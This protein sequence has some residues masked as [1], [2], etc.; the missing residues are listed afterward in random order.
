MRISSG[1]GKHVFA[2]GIYL[3][4]LV[5]VPWLHIN[6]VIALSATLGSLYFSE[7]MKFP[8]C[9]LCWYQR[10][11]IYPLVGIFCAALLTEDRHHLKYSVPLLVL[12]LTLAIYHNLLY[13]G[14]IA[15]ELVPCT[16][17]VSCSSRQLEL[18]GF[19]TIPL[20]AL[21]SF[22]TMLFVV[23]FEY[24]SYDQL[25]S[26]TFAEQKGQPSCFVVDILAKS[27]SS[28]NRCPAVMS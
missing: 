3:K 2:G 5:L 13:F 25:R 26:S 20:L 28:P 19:I 27:T 12:G 17:A 6:F 18:Y 15:Q 10:I 11:C 8:P 7:I 16:G 23:F 14:V 21:I 24:C 22:A 1:A 4:F 9:T